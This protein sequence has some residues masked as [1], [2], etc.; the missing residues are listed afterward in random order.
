ME[1]T[2]AQYTQDKACE[3]SWDTVTIN[4]WA[5]LQGLEHSSRGEYD[6]SEIFLVG[7]QDSPDKSPVRQNED[8][9]LSRW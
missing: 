6:Q 1:L 3:A 2:F 7:G 9:H 8:I 4:L 5:F